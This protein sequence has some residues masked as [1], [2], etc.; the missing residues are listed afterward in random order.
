MALSWRLAAL[1]A[2]VAYLLYK[3]REALYQWLER[4]HAE[5]DL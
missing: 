1:Y 2:V 5:E 4:W 3:H